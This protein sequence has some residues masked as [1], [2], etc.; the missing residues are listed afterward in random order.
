MSEHEQS[1]ISLV[2]VLVVIAVTGALAW[3][4]VQWL[5]AA[6][7]SART[8]ALKNRGRGIWVSI[9]S[10]NMEREPFKRCPLWPYEFTLPVDQGGAGQTCA[11]ASDYFRK[12]MEGD[13]PE[14]QLVTDLKPEMLA[15][16]GF[17]PA[18]SA[19]TLTPANIA[20]RVA[21]VSEGFA[22]GDAFMITKDLA[23]V[24]RSGASNDVITLSRRG[25]YK[26][27]RVVWV[28]RGGGVYDARRKYARNWGVFFNQTNNVPFLAD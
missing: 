25:P 1:E 4:I 18:A 9:I 28:T 12:L 6:G 3:V 19:A 16:S 5:A 8:S 2:E 24:A 23:A 27:K 22:S 17:Y 21:E 15:S 26:G 14:S 11:G 10:A 20:W 13:R 7:D